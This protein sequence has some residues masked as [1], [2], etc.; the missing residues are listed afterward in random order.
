MSLSV[1]SERVQA[2]RYLQVTRQLLSCS[3]DGGITVW[4]MDTHRDEVSPLTPGTLGPRRAA[5]SPAGRTGAW[6]HM[7]H[8]PSRSRI[9]SSFQS[10]STLTREDVIG[11]GSWDGVARGHRVGEAGCGAR[12]VA[13]V[14]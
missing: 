6:A 12:G 10:G 9:I 14:T 11:G 13:W 2:V 5:L 8:T 1:P 4:N 3:A 7:H